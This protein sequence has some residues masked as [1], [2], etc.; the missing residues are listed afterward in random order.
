MANAPV[1][2]PVSAA[3]GKIK[4]KKLLD[5]VE[6]VAA[7]CRPDRVYLCDGSDQEY[8][9][10]IRIMLQSG[11]AISLNPERRPNSIYVRSTTVDVARV[12]DRTFICSKTQ[13]EAGPNNNWEE[14][15]R[16]RRRLTELFTGSM[17]GR[18]MYVIPY[19]MGP[20][21]SPIAKVG[22]EISDSPY[23]VAN[24]H[25][26][27]R[28]GTKVLEQLGA[29]GDFVKGWHSVGAPIGPNEQD[30]A[31]PCNSEHKY[32]CHFPETREILSFGSGYGGN[33][34][35]GK[36]C[37][38]LR[39]ASVQARDEGWL[40]EHMLILKLTSPKGE[41]KYVTGA[42]PSACGK[43]N[44]AMLIS[45]V[46]GWKVETIGDDIA[47]MKFGDDG[48]LYAINPEAGFFGVA[49]G[50]SMKSNPNA[51]LTIT[52]NSIFTNCALTPDGDVW[53]EG[54][55]D[56]KPAELMDWLRRQW[57]PD[58]ARLAS[59][60]NARFT[61]PAKQCPVIAKEWEDPKGVPIDAILFGGR[62]ATVIPL[63]IESF[64]WQHGTFLG[65]TAS[66]ET[67]AAAA[68]KVGQLRRD[69]MAMLPFCGYDMGSYFAHWLKIGATPGAK[70]PKI[71][72]VNWFRKD[73]KGKFLWPG[74]GENSRVLKWIFERC[75]GTANAVDTP[76]GRLPRPE[77]LD[78]GG[79][80]IPAANL[81]KLL[82]VDVEGW[83]GEIP[84]IHQFFD[85]FGERLPKALRDEVNRL[86]Q[87][88]KK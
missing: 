5:W 56:E 67:T 2:S 47:W 88:L 73:E 11:S 38:A 77:D 17:R 69:P 66:S 57:T 21:G 71:F 78:V 65:A 20:L 87:R 18:T 43:T 82:N 54:M 79:L 41:V 29:D 26:M 68:G 42:F 70:M 13:D 33:A 14:P 35:L 72:V 28:V 30:S 31:W 36:K 60:A 86:E 63:V 15:T 32:I 59:H 10:M 4:N 40:A 3:A 55:T 6:E 25:I 75:N 52:K 19:C 34:L 61:T 23:V 49:P 8:Q 58:S 24:M 50:T 85:Q 12:E 81:S 27:A 84:L 62:R 45:T 7:M 80:D 16:M 51:M 74:Y 48:R 76:I 44:L 1:D 83:L 53:W 64:D 22:V 39:I 37:H 9:L 46:P